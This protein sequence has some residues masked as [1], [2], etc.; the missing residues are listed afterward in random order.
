MRVAPQVYVRHSFE[1]STVPGQ[2]RLLQQQIW[3]PTVS[4]RLQ[5]AQVKRADVVF[6]YAFKH[7]QPWASH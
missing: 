7:L 5:A 4:A 3:S 2:L 6:L 1:P